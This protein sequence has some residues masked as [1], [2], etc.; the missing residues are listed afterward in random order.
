MDGDDPCQQLGEDC[1]E[2]MTS[3]VEEVKHFLQ[4]GKT[5]ATVIPS[6]LVLVLQ[7]LAISINQPFK[8]HL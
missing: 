3:F 2:P 5:D 7:P 1:T 4:E 6:G 8:G